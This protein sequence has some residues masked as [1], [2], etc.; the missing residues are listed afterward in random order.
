MDRLLGQIEGLEIDLNKYE[1]KYTIN[2]AFQNSGKIYYSTNRFRTL[3]HLGK[4]L[5]SHSTSKENLRLRPATCYSV[6]F[7]LYFIL[8]Y[9][10]SKC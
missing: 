5:F 2:V 8:F 4:K 9:F 6:T 7:Q 1:I 3:S 10:T